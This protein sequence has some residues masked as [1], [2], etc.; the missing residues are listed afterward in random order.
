MLLLL[1]PLLLFVC[2]AMIARSM[3]RKPAFQGALNAEHASFGKQLSASTLILI[4][5]NQ[6]EITD[7]FHLSSWKSPI[8]PLL[9]PACRARSSCAASVPLPHSGMCCILP[10]PVDS[11]VKSG[12]T[13]WIPSIRLSAPG[14]SSAVAMHEFYLPI[15]EAQQQ[16]LSFWPF[17]MFYN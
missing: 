9:C 13:T 15:R 4:L 16:V 3:T 8:I 11:S 7:I 14:R 1:P 17:T 5:P 6:L 12:Q 10:Q 2:T